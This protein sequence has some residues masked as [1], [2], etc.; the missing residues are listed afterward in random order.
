ME[1]GIA[2]DAAP[3]PPDLDESSSPAIAALARESAL[4]VAL[5]RESGFAG[6]RNWLFNLGLPSLPP[7]F[8]LLWREDYAPK[9][10]PPLL[11]LRW[12]PL[13]FFKSVKK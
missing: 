1:G 10:R 11:P 6:V 13:L 8:P 9:L 3:S 12:A 5:E 4:L 2:F 7:L